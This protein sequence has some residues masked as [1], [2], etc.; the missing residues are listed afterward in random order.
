MAGGTAVAEALL[1]VRG[2]A[3][4]F[5]AV[6]ACDALDLDLHPGELHAVIGPNGAGKTTLISLIAGELEPDAGAIRFAG[7]EIAGEAPEQR[8][9]RG[10]ARSFQVT[11]LFPS[12]S[13]LDN[14]AL[15]V[16]AHAGHSFR[17]WRPARDLGALREPAREALER[18]GL[19][20]RADEAAGRLSHGEQ[21]QL[22]IAMALAGRP[23]LLLLDEPMAGMGA[24]ESARMVEL[25][26][27]LK[28]DHALLLVEHDM[29]AVFSLADRITV[30]V[31]GR[32]I[33][34]GSVE[35]VRASPAVREAYLGGAEEAGDA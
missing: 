18:V 29:D 8:A 7:E 27:G 15:A 10:L 6:V 11:S 28:G 25:L 3:K 34:S 2:L 22:E 26:D 12:F 21:R 19:G 14:V 13:A 17:F 35:A 24:D 31:Y 32:P 23:R 9:A 16:Q 1:E 20:G 4:R 30:L 33:A 5:G